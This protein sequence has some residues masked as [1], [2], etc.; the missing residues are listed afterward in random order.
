[1]IV[2]I[3][4]TNTSPGCCSIGSIR[5]N[6]MTLKTVIGRVVTPIDRGNNNLSGKV[7]YLKSV[8][9]MNEFFTQVKF[10]SVKSHTG[11]TVKIV[12]IRE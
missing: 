6:T 9:F 1:M 12:K 11:P 5:L 10:A 2:I 4:D 3:S 7:F 8:V